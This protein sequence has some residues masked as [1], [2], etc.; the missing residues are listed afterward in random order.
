[1]ITSRAI[2]RSDIFRLSL[3]KFQY[4]SPHE[5]LSIMLHLN[6]DEFAN[7]SLCL[8]CLSTILDLTLGNMI[9]NTTN[10]QHVNIHTCSYNLLSI[11]EGM[12]VYLD[13]A[14]GKKKCIRKINK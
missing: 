2:F 4:D 3:S 8:L 1:M 10:R 14:V 11:Y 13:Y 7:S 9:F 5:E 6:C 12:M